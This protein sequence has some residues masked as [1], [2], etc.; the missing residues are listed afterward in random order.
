MFM[1]RAKL[2]RSGRLQDALITTFYVGT[3]VLSRRVCGRALRVVRF[4]GYL[5][6]AGRRTFYWRTAKALP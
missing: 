3:L 6:H 5:L 4:C 1:V 2:G